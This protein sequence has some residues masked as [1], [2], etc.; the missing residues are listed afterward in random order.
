MRFGVNNLVFTTGSGTSATVGTSSI[1]GGLR[2][3]MVA[4]VASNVV[5]AG[6]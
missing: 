5:S 6:G 1:V 4:V 3:L 2:L